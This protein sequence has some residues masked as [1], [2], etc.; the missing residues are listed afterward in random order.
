MNSDRLLNTTISARSLATAMALVATSLW[1]TSAWAC[2]TCKEALAGNGGGG[3]LAAAFSYS[4]LFMM[5]MPFLLTGAVSLGM[6]RA[7]L[8]ARATGWGQS[9]DE[10]PSDDV[11]AR[12]PTA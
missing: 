2:P 8:Q 10:A 11:S 7:V 6:H 1:N 9:L 5:A 12:E 4:I 3:D